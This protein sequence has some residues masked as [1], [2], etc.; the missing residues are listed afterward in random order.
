MRT[1]ISC[2]G[3]K[4]KGELLRLVVGQSGWVER[5]EK[6]QGKGRGAYLCRNDACL[7]VL[8]TG[9]G[10]SRAFRRKVSLPL[11]RD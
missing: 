4:S 9:K 2:G 1:C 11:L 5:D 3:K 7:T 10:L 8:K 6:G